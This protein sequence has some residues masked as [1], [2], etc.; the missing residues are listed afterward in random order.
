MTSIL[1]VAILMV[2]AAYVCAAAYVRYSVLSFGRAA[3][4]QAQ[5]TDDLRSFVESDAPPAV[6]R[7]AIQLGTM[8]GCGCF[9]RGM[10]VSHYLPRIALTVG[11]NAD[12]I[13]RAFDEAGAMAAEQQSA[14]GRITALVVLYD[15]FRNPLQ[16]WLFRRMMRTYVR[17]EQRWDSQ[18]ETKLATFSVMSRRYAA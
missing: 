1:I 11:D 7:L 2:P 12:H 10:L 17:H 5:L 15:S 13:Q 18:L 16:G 4:L 6:S 8:T 14:F 9:V 3:Q